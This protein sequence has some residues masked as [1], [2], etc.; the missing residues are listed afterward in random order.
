M[1]NSRAQIPQPAAR[2]NGN[3]SVSART[4]SGNLARATPWFRVVGVGLRWSGSGT[5]LTGIARLPGNPGLA[6][7]Q[8]WRT[9]AAQCSFPGVSREFR[10]FRQAFSRSGSGV[11]HV[12]PRSGDILH[13]PAIARTHDSEP[14]NPGA[15]DASSAEEREICPA[16]IAPD[17]SVFRLQ[18]ACDAVVVP[19]VVPLA[20][21]AGR[22]NGRNPGPPT[23]STPVTP[24][25]GRP[26]VS[27]P[28]TLCPRHTPV[29]S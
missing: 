11:R 3:C 5:R 14:A 17:L 25:R 29:L 19:V 18:H 7:R 23:S 28:S 2:V 9:V 20:R 4:F 1:W 15:A 22:G 10:G 8:T 21:A 6:S 16:V 24:C 12:R 13:R 27:G 26:G